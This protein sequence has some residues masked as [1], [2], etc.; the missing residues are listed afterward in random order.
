MIFDFV[1]FVSPQFRIVAIY[2]KYRFLKRRY[3]CIFQIWNSSVNSSL[4]T[5]G[6]TREEGGLKWQCYVD[7]YIFQLHR[8]RVLS[9]QFS[10]GVTTY[11]NDSILNFLDVIKNFI[12]IETWPAMSA[13]NR[14][15]DWCQWESVNVA[16][17]LYSKEIF[18]GTC[19]TLGTYPVKPSL[20]VRQACE[21]S[22][23]LHCCLSE[24]CVPTASASGRQP[25]RLTASC[26]SS[27]HH[28]SAEFRCRWTVTCGT[29]FT[30]F[31]SVQAFLPWNPVK[32]V[33]CLA[34]LSCLF[35]FVSQI[36]DWLI[37]WLLT[38]VCC[39]VRSRE[40]WPRRGWYVW[41]WRR[42]TVTWTAR[43]RLQ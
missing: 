28:R 9:C 8:S 2:V 4:R 25:R 3:P 7:C 27:N 40:E 26:H 29:V 10:R 32:L 39:Y 5:D 24:L 1:T 19:N 33:Y 31:L 18:C 12:A 23:R 43:R 37:E 17:V 30:E 38:V 21:R 36:Y 14:T 41:R 34:S 22:K 6:P 13:A 16:T 11:I 35:I 20:R 15:L 42:M